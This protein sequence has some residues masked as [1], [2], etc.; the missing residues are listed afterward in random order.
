M[1]K[2]TRKRSAFKT[3]RRLGIELPGLGRPG[4]LAKRPYP[5]GMHGQGRQR[6]SEYGT[7]LAEKQ[8][9]VYHYGMGESQLRRFVK[10]AKKGSSRNWVETFLGSLESRLDNI[11]FRL[12]FT[13]SI[14][15]A[16]QM[17]VHG[18]V[19]VNGKKARTPSMILSVGSS[20][21]SSMTICGNG[22]AD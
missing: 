18:H 5:P 2:A 12:G 8:K 19:F 22:L 17:V 6:K 13:R 9:L 4:A 7:R 11:V 16:R 21:K 15:A 1:S 3:Q 10:H 20:R 14:P